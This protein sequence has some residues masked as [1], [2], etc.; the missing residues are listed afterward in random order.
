MP[1]TALADADDDAAAAAAVADEISN[2]LLFA[3]RAAFFLPF[4]GLL[5]PAPP[6]LE[7]VT[8]AVLLPVFFAV[9][10]P[11]LTILV[12]FFFGNIT[13]S[14]SWLIDLLANLLC[15]LA[16]REAAGDRLEI[17]AFVSLSVERFRRRDKG[18]ID[19]R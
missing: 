5:P 15:P 18:E 13:I 1:A 16:F 9:D 4:L 6:V 14:L 8:L 2:R 19:L 10:S 17:L 11:V 7:S 12:D 3:V